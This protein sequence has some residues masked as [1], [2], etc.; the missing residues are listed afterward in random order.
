MARPRRIEGRKTALE[1]MEDAFW[2]MLAEMPYHQMTGRELRA[3][4]GVSHNTFYYYFASKEELMEAMVARTI[5]TGIEA[6][7]ALAS[8]ATLSAEDKLRLIIAAPGSDAAQRDGFAEELHQ[9]N[10]AELH[11][12]SIVESVRRLAPPITR[13]VEQGIAEGAFKNPCPK[14]T[15][16]FLLTASQFLLDTGIFGGS[17]E[18]L[19]SRANAF[20][21][22]METSLAARPGSFSYIATRYEDMLNNQKQHMRKG[23]EQ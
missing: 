3:R 6:V 5:D 1:R 14:E 11:L 15:V 4:A 13:I 8:D 23:K 19:L 17:E 10:N 21:H 22:V 18:A 12:H 2:D 7:E 16:E 20:A 9:S